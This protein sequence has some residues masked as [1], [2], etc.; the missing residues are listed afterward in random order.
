MNLT[1][2]YHNNN[3]S[4]W[5]M[6]ASG[7]A[8]FWRI[9]NASYPVVFMRVNALWGQQ[10]SLVWKSKQLASLQ[11]SYYFRERN[12]T[13]KIGLYSMYKLSLHS[14]WWRSKVTQEWSKAV[15]DSNSWLTVLLWNFSENTIL[16]PKMLS[17]SMRKA[18]FKNLGVFEEDEWPLNGNHHGLVI[19]VILDI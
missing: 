19:F 4:I 7:R 1:P 12:C 10:Q 3:T 17:K 16:V 11:E 15:D 6:W 8:C 14:V 2:E 9:M 5:E 13:S 18:V